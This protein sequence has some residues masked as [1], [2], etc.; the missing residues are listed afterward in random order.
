M[1]IRLL[2][3]FCGLVFMASCSPKITTSVTKPY[4]PLAP[5]DE[6]LVMGVNTAEPAGELVGYVKVGDTGF[7]TQCSFEVVIE[8][9]KQEAR[10]MGGNVLKLVSHDPPDFFTSSCHRITANIFLVSNLAEVEQINLSSF[11]KESM[12]H[13]PTVTP[14]TPLSEELPPLVFSE[15]DY[16][17]WRIAVNGVPSFRIASLQDGLTNAEREYVRK[18]KSGYF[19]SGEVSHF[20]SETF[21]IGARYSMYR[22]RHQSNMQIML[23]DGTLI[24]GEVSD[25]ITIQYV[26]PSIISRYPQQDGKGMWYTDFS[27]GYIHYKNISTLGSSFLTIDGG[28]FGIGLGLGYDI[29]LSDQF[30]LGL[31]VSMVAGTLTK[32]NLRNGFSTTTIKLEEEEYEGLARVDITLGLRLYK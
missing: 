2:L 24:T 15:R 11:E 1:S 22:S 27:M 18:L 26:G 9:A 29:V 25:N 19:F 3:A 8:K 23:M 30:G 4:Q 12:A 5:Q 16:S 28:S 14:P 13:S 21:G 17:K 7:T 6:V 20:V 10:K 32:V 31:G